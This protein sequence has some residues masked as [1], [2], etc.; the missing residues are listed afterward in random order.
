M[1]FIQT[2]VD[3]SAVI[4]S[5]TACSRRAVLKS[6]PVA[7]AFDSREAYT[8]KVV[9]QSVWDYVCTSRGLPCVNVDALPQDTIQTQ[10]RKR[11]SPDAQVYTFSSE[12]DVKHE[13][14]TRGP[15]MSAIQVSRHFLQF[16]NKLLETGTD[17]V[18]D[19][20]Q[21]EKSHKTKEKHSRVVTLAIVGW[22]G[23]AWIVANGWSTPRVDKPLVW[24]H[25][26]FFKLRNASSSTVVS[27]ATAMLP[28]A[29]FET[30]RA[31][32]GIVVWVVSP[33][34]RRPVVK[35]NAKVAVR[36]GDNASLDNNKFTKWFD[37]Q[38]IMGTLVLASILVCL[39]VIIC[40]H[41]VRAFKHAE[42]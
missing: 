27:N 3:N 20:E 8:S 30:N 13:I 31:T 19:Y 2:P 10:C 33:P 38:H 21:Q 22:D 5:V 15:V 25:N 42:K 24:G 4:E 28:L 36:H 41:L 7:A 11:S 34:S 16:W 26:G 39:L 18:F 9:P 37:A 12:Q 29:A 1:W 14:A 17:H 40:V 23:D 32:S 35:V 6:A